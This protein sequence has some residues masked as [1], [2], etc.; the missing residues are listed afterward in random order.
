M[1]SPPPKRPWTLVGNR[2]ET[3]LSDTLD[4]PIPSQSTAWSTSSLGSHYR[5]VGKG[6]AR[7]GRGRRRA[8]GRSARG[9]RGRRRAVGRSA[10]GGGRGRRREVGR[11]VRIPG[12]GR[13]RRGERLDRRLQHPR[14]AGFADWKDGGGWR[15]G[16]LTWGKN[17]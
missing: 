2:P 13:G 7:G 9:G 8:V 16:K 15:T 6:R 3:D 4:N 14:S 11:S 17:V 1:V 5:R 12:R 10:R